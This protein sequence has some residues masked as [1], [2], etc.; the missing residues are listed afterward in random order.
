MTKRKPLLETAEFKNFKAIVDGCH[1]AGL[2]V[3]LSEREDTVRIAVSD[4]EK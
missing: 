1:K 3:E 2:N 4:E